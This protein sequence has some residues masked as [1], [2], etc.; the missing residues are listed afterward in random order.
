MI[1]L[2][3]Q[4]RGFTLIELLV[5]ISIIGL[6]SSVVLAS[7]QEARVRARDTSLKSSFISLRSNIENEYTS[8]GLSFTDIC[9]SSP[10]SN[11][12]AMIA[13]NFGGEGE[14]GGEFTENYACLGWANF[15]V[16]ILRLPDQTFYCQGNLGEVIGKVYT[17]IDP[18]FEYDPDDPTLPCAN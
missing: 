1:K 3:A 18:Q 11:Q 17:M 5:V 7:L 15:Y 8:N 6:L 13:D 10:V 9:D 4:K 2:F 14:I 16:V 12:L